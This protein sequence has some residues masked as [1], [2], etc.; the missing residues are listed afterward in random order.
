MDRNTAG[1]V[2]AAEVIEAAAKLYKKLMH[3]HWMDGKKQRKINSDFSKLLL[4]MDLTEMER[5]L[6]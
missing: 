4:A 6:Q 3:G 1:N 5:N 2:H